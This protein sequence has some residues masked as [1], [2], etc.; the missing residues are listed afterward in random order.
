MCTTQEHSNQAFRRNGKKDAGRKDK[1]A[2]SS[3][4]MASELNFKITSQTFL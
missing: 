4:A 1:V 3:K 2:I